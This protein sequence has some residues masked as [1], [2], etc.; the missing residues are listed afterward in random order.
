MMD[1]DSPPC[2][3][4]TGPINSTRTSGRSYRSHLDSWFT[5]AALEFAEFAA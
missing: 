2:S 3:T 5:D 4:I 1:L